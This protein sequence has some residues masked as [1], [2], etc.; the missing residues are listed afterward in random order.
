MGVVAEAILSRI[1]EKAVNRTCN[2]YKSNSLYIKALIL[3]LGII[4][5][6]RADI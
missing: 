1:L 2:T 4:H 6:W 3:R 5:L